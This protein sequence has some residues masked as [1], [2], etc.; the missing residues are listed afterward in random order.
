MTFFAITNGLM[1]ANT[2]LRRCPRLVL[3]VCTLAGTLVLWPGVP[4]RAEGPARAAPDWLDPVQDYQRLKQFVG[5]IR[6]VEIVE[7]VSAIA[8]GSEMGPGDGWFHDS[9]TRYDWK[10]LAARFDANH[11]GTI[12]RQEFGGPK[13][14]FERLDRNHDG[15]LTSRD[16]DWSDRSIFAMQSMPARYWFSR[17][18]SNS[19]GR[20]SREE[21]DAVYTRMAQG[22]GYV[23]PD[24][25]REAFPTSPP[26]RPAGSPPPSNTG[27]S[28]LTLLKGLANGELGSPFEGPGIGDRAPEFALRTQDGKRTIRLAQ[29]RGTKPVVL[30]FGSF[31]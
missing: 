2:R 17:I 13:E 29:Y 15:V 24:D 26:P 8:Q 18:D 23:T 27:P 11:D 1:L 3:T 19:N 28:P 31:T 16:F 9:K 30:V 25:L 21:W 12:T 20:I 7:M 5:K 22:K 4:S 6:Q 14:L 10:W